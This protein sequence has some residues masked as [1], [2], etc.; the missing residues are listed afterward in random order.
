MLQKGG[1]KDCRS[2]LKLGLAPK[3]SWSHSS[4]SLSSLSQTGSERGNPPHW[5]ETNGGALQDLP[6]NLKLRRKA[7]GDGA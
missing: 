4:L 3:N 2:W 1:G 5:S 6:G 7:N